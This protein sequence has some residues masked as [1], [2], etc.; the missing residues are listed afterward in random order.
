MQSLWNVLDRGYTSQEAVDAPRWHDQLGGGGGRVG[1]EETEFVIEGRF[2][3]VIAAEM[4]RRGHKVKEVGVAGSS[5]CGLRV[6]SKGVEGDNKEGEWGFEVG[7]ERRRR[8][9]AGGIVVM[10]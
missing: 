5:M 2:S 6:W 7:W 9:D 4:R 10:G 3:R 1:T 8:R